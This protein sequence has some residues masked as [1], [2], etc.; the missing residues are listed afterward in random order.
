MLASGRP[1]QFFSEPISDTDVAR[2]GFVRGSPDGQQ[3]WESLAALIAIR[4]WKHTWA[5]GT[6]TLMV[7]GDSVTMLTLVVN[8]RPASA[9]LALIGQELALDF[10]SAAF[11][12]IITQHIP[13]VANVLADKLSRRMQA[14]YDPKIPSQ[15][16]DAK[17]VYPPDRNDSYF[18]TLQTQMPNK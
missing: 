8:M 14:G 10:A 2:F 1:I 18:L 9:S 12:P 5:S 7:K 16:S 4:L 17:L 3:V 11:A 13:G 15:L 6:S